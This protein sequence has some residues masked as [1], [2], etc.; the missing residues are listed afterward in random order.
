MRSTSNWSPRLRVLMLRCFLAPIGAFDVARFL[1]PTGAMV[2]SQGLPAPGPRSHSGP[3]GWKPLA[4]L[5]CPFGAKNKQRNIKTYASGWR[6]RRDKCAK[7]NPSSRTIEPAPISADRSRPM[8]CKNATFGHRRA[9]AG[10]VSSTRSFYPAACPDGCSLSV[11]FT[12][13][14][15]QVSARACETIWS[16]V[17]RFDVAFFFAPTGAMVNSQGLP[18]P[19]PRSH[20]GPRG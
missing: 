16:T 8:L 7:C 10:P 18:A 9:H 3:R 14:G 6:G 17:T 1:G 11:G 15:E 4:I 19:G 5:R 12:Q 2:N 13:G 20:S